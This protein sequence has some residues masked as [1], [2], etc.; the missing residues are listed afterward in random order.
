MFTPLHIIV[1]IVYILKT[2]TIIKNHSD[3][4]NSKILI[5]FYVLAHLIFI[6]GILYLLGG[7]LICFP[8]ELYVFISRFLCGLQYS[9]VLLVIYRIHTLLRYMK[10]VG[11]K[12]N[13]LGIALISLIVVY[14][15]LCNGV[16]LIAST[17]DLSFYFLL[18]YDALL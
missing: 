1:E 17:Y 6:Q 14:C 11:S 4:I 12:K 8:K 16:N 13:Y 3:L 18:N 9:V 15:I 5:L 10:N 2:I 7:V